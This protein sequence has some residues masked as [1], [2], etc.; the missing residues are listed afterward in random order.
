MSTEMSTNMSTITSTDP[1][2]EYIAMVTLGKAILEKRNYE[3]AMKNLECAKAYLEKADDT[4]KE[5]AK[6]ILSYS[7]KVVL[8][9]RCIMEGL[10]PDP[11]PPSATSMHL[12]GQGALCKVGVKRSRGE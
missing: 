6:K 3:K 7:E 1:Q 12:A 4:Q 2:T 11:N 5:E 8:Y 9:Y 10:F